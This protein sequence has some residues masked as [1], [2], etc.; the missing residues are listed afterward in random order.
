MVRGLGGY[1]CDPTFDKRCTLDYDKFKRALES[2]TR[3]EALDEQICP[4]CQLFGCTGWKRRFSLNIT[5]QNTEITNDIL[6]IRPYGRTRGWYLPVGITGKVTL[7]LRGE[8]KAV[9]KIV[10]LLHWLARWGSI[11]AKSQ[12]GYGVFKVLEPRPPDA[13]TDNLAGKKLPDLRVLPDLRAFTFFTFQ[14]KPRNEMW[15]KQLRDFQY[16]MR[17]KPQTWEGLARQN[18]IPVSPLLKNYLRYRKEWK[19]YG[20]PKWLFGFI[21]GEKRQKGRVNFSWAY[22]VGD[23]WEIKGW[24]WLPYEARSRYVFSDAVR[25]LRDV[26]EDETEWLKALDLQG[27]VSEAK[28][29]IE[30][31]KSPW[32]IKESDTVMKLLKGEII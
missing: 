16:T 5:S 25:G 29:Y 22:K 2:K 11:G 3:Q 14:F 21:E 26:V 13:I 27:K 4:A 8:E 1:A 7:Q 9:G 28:V 15:W 31:G 20:I 30:P 19:S 24:A 10:S 6:N 23:H 32:G 17:E 12:L 18:M